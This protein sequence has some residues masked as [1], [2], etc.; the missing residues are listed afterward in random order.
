MSEGGEKGLAAML[1]AMRPRAVEVEPVVDIAAERASAFAEGEVAGAARAEVEL[2][3]LRLALAEA[4]AALQAA[5]AID[6]DQ[7]RPLLAELIRQI[8][9][10]VVMAEL[11][12]DPS[13]VLRLIEAGLAMVRP[14]EAPTLRV[15]PEMLDRLRPWLPDVAAVAD[16][17]LAIDA[18]AVSGGD[19]VIEAGLVA[20]LDAVMEGVA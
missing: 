18:F 20:R 1:A 19:F 13:V 16:P 7:V 11:R 6:V 9:E 14:G 15:H 3:P 2:A 4:A 5:A 12:L 10:T 17:A 8:C